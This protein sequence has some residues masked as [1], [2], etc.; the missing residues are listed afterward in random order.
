MLV[1]QPDPVNVNPHL[2]L[3]SPAYAVGTMSSLGRASLA[4]T[5]PMIGP[6]HHG[7]R[8]IAGSVHRYN[9]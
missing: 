5:L 3:I 6:F 8:S 4:P 2:A 7:N 1:Q 9:K